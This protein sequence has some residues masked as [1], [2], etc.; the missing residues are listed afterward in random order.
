MPVISSVVGVVEVVVSLVF[1]VVL[2][3]LRTDVDVG[4]LP[5]VLMG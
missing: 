2:V 5:V 3:F 4:L 1:F